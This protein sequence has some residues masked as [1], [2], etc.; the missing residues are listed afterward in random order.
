MAF[1]MLEAFS[2]SNWRTGVGYGDVELIL[3]GGKTV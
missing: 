3:L 1:H 2:P